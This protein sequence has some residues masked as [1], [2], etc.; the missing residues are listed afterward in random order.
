MTEIQKKDLGSEHK[1]VVESAVEL[2]QDS[3]PI[4]VGLS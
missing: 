2:K 3:D 1:F 4:R